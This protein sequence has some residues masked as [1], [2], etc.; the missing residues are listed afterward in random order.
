MSLLFPNNYVRLSECHS[1]AEWLDANPDL[2]NEHALDVLYTA[3]WPDL[4][5][6]DRDSTWIVGDTRLTAGRAIGALLA[7]ETAGRGA[8]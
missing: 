8:K 5:W 2:P 7:R 3:A 6:S 4:D 1:L